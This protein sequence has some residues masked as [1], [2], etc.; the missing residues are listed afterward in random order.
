MIEIGK[1]GSTK[2][3]K[4]EVQGGYSSN[5]SCTEMRDELLDNQKS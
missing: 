1:S 5:R 4:T 3:Q 2:Y